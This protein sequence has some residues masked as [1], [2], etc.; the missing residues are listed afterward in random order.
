LVKHAGIAPDGWA[1][2]ERRR[3]SDEEAE[4]L[5]QRFEGASAKL[6]E[7]A[8]KDAEACHLWRLLKARGLAVAEAAAQIKG[9]FGLAKSAVYD[10]LTRIRGFDA[11][12]WPALLVGQ[13][14]GENAKRVEWPEGAW[15]FFLRHALPPGAKIKTAWRR[16]QREA[17]KQ[18]WGVIPSYDT[19]KEDYRRIDDDVR[20][21]IKEGETALKAKS[22]QVRR[23]YDGPLHD[24]WSLD[25]RRQDVMVFDRY[26]KY[27]PPGRVFRVWLL[28][29]EEVRS[30]MLVGY[31]MGG[32]LNADLVRAAFLNAVKTTGRI[33]PRTI[34]CDNGMENA[35]KEITGGAPWRRRGKIKD[36]DIIGLFPRLS[37]DVEWATPA[38]GQTKPIE[39][40]FG[41]LANLVETRPEFRGAYCGRTP[42][43][44]PEEWDAA[45]AVPVEIL[46]QLFAEELHA[47]HRTPHRGE[48]MGRRPPLTVYETLMRQPD[49]AARRI[50]EAQLRTCAYSASK[51]TIGKDGRFTLF[52]GRYGSEAA[53]KLAPGRG[54]YALYDPH[55]LSASTFVYRGERRLC[56]ARRIELTPYNDKAAAKRVMKARANYMNAVR[57]QSDALAV[58]SADDSKGYL[59]RLAREVLPD[60]VDPET[61][62]ILPAPKVIEIVHG[63]AD[64]VPNTKP[65]VETEDEAILREARRMQEEDAKGL[66]ERVRARA[67]GGR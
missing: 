41:T 36:D 49:C 61:G 62:E 26:G 64:A 34:Q 2:D 8:Y 63:K 15:L 17:E 4:V 23:A 20:V 65:A 32:A 59:E 46:E 56:E 50:S 35:A 22:P 21:L 31:A 58:R 47:Y 13:W 53:A 52:G 33:I 29:I 6:K 19:A 30:R 42:E 28:G 9:D 12:H 37:I 27:G 60:K 10:K 11:Q 18:G 66:A 3:L 39:R 14:T 51:I 45:K 24:K 57:A 48:G 1:D 67:L 25:G 40:L 44:R 5:W 16:T 43:A 38:H 54:Y 7:R 55:D